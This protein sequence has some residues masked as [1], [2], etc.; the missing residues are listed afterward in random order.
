M[1]NSCP[2]NYSN[3]R[4]E[5]LKLLFFSSL[6]IFF[7]LRFSLYL[8]LITDKNPCPVRKNKHPLLR[9]SALFKMA[10][11]VVRFPIFLVIRA[12]G[13]V[14]A[15]LVLSWTV[16]YRGGLALVSEN[17]D[18]IFN[19]SSWYC[20]GSPPFFF[21]FFEFC[22]LWISCLLLRGAL[23]VHPV[24]MVISLVLLNGE[25]KYSILVLWFWGCV[26]WLGF[27]F[28]FVAEC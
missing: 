20:F 6:L 23:Q 22:N 25:G 1:N 5:K 9:F 11:P 2:Q 10:I 12:I 4:L 24:L 19:V 13:F 27:V 7:V 14:V 16:H 18:L 17:K 28:C 3:W 26:W 21:F 8:S 15:T